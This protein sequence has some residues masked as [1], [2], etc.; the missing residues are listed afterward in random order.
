MKVTLVFE[1]AAHK[2]LKMQV[3]HLKTVKSSPG[4]FVAS[5]EVST[6]PDARFRLEVKTFQNNFVRQIYGCSFFA[7]CWK[8]PA[9]NGVC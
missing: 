4:P 1:I 3:K 8:L 7:Y 6:R 2:S 5:F 9:Y